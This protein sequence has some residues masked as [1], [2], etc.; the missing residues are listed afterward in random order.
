MRHFLFI[1]NLVPPSLSSRSMRS[2]L[3]A[4]PYRRHSCFM[5]FLLST[6]EGRWW[7]RWWWFPPTAA[8]PWSKSS[9]KEKM[10]VPVWSFI[11]LSTIDSVLLLLST[12]EEPSSMCEVRSL[13]FLSP[14]SLCAPRFWEGQRTL[15]K[16]PRRWLYYVR[17]ESCERLMIGGSIPQ[18]SFP[19]G[20]E[21]RGCQKI[22]KLR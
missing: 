9:P 22:Q 7:W 21:W 2:F 8:G 12:G 4:A 13:L 20:K 1:S 3:L 19:A 11:L 18:T 15:R 16:K 10:I 14:I 6:I 17:G 5:L